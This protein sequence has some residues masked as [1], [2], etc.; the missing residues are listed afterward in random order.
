VYGAFRARG[1]RVEEFEGVRYRRIDRLKQLLDDGR[2]DASLRW[3][4]AARTERYAVSPSLM[5]DS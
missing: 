3:R 4:D 2:L 1:V 5:G